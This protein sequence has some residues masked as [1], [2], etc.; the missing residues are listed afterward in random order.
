MKKSFSKRLKFTSK[1]KLLRRAMV[2]GHSKGN[3]SQTAIKR[4]KQMRGL[5]LKKRTT[6]KYF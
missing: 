4:K 6:K 1:G 3:K 5:N 2:L